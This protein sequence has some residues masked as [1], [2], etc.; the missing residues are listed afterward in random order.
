M[1]KKKEC[2]RLDIGRTKVNKK[3]CIICEDPRNPK[4]HRISKMAIMHAF[5]CTNI[6]ITLESRSCRSHFEKGKTKSKLN[7]DGLKNLSKFS[8]N[9]ELNANQITNIIQY[10]RKES[11]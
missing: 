4:L 10:L 9:I 11:F 7:D 6:L 8:D 2:I 5:I 1:Q 3:V